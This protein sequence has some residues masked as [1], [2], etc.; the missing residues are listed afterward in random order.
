MYNISKFL[1]RFKNLKSPKIDREEVAKVL[2]ECLGFEISPNLIS[3]KN[4]V[5]QFSGNSSLRVEIYM[6]KEKL[7]KM[8]TE[9]LP[10]LHIKD[11][12]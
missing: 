7:L 9:K 5:I 10:H 12:R 1:S 11:I 6:K 2:T 4:Y 8:L 3:L